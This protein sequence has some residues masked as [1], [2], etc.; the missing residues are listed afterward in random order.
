MS[1]TGPEEGLLVAVGCGDDQDRCADLGSDA[2]DAGVVGGAQL[3]VVVG[4]CTGL[5]EPRGQVG[6]L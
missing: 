2:V 4:G 5:S 1:R 3:G 6:A